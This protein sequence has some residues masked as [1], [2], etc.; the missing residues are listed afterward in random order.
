MTREFIVG[1]LPGEIDED[2]LKR[3]G[4][5]LVK[6]QR[7][8]LPGVTVDISG[9]AR[10]LYLFVAQGFSFVALAGDEI[11]GVLI[12]VE[13]TRSWAA[14]EDNTCLADQAFVVAKE[15]RGKGVREALMTAGAA[16]ARKAGKTAFIFKAVPL[17]DRKDRAFPVR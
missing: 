12:L 16:A 3:I 15:W 7:D 10:N 11:V 13:V 4:M 1:H 9:A 5:F 8:L 14:A 2:T 6:H 17:V